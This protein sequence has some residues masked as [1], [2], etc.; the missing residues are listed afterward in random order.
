MEGAQ[1]TSQNRNNTS[2]RIG[3]HPDPDFLALCLR[4]KRCDVVVFR[5]A[6]WLPKRARMRKHAC[7]REV[8]A[9]LHLTR[10]RRLRTVY[11]VVGGATEP[12]G[13]RSMQVVTEIGARKGREAGCDSV[14]FRIVMAEAAKKKADAYPYLSPP[15]ETALTVVNAPL[16]KESNWT[17]SKPHRKGE[18]TQKK[19]SPPPSE[20][21]NWTQR[22]A[23]PGCP[24]NAPARWG[25]ASSRS[26]FE[27]LWLGRRTRSSRSTSRRASV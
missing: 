17:H 23:T 26:F 16:G 3:A 18:R 8:L 1:W 13:P 12:N 6:R 20:E 2:T 7:W 4:P 14:V 24:T 22:R 15:T 27:L 11:T 21:P 9:R 5:I 10:A 19:S 25:G